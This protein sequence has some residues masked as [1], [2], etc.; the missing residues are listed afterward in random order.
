[1]LPL[2]LKDSQLQFSAYLKDIS[3]DYNRPEKLGRLMTDIQT[4]DASQLLEL[5]AQF[6]LSFAQTDFST[7]DEKGQAWSNFADATLQRALE[8][9][10]AESAKRHRFPID[11]KTP[12]GLFILGLGKLGGYD[13]NFSSDVD[14]I[15]FFDPDHFP[16]PEHKGQAYIASDI[17]KR[18][19]QILYPVSYTHLTLP[20]TPYV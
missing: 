5:K 8:L 11:S 7:F 15:A 16:V 10:W 18:M 9:A 2:T 6:S 12:T 4:S 13:L 20:T 3:E 14:L 17:C 19:T 1:M